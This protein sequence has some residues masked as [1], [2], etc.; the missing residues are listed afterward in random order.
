[1]RN[2]SRVAL[3]WNLANDPS[4]GPHTQGGC[5]TCKGALTIN[6]D[7]ITRNVGYYII[8][9]A[10]KFIP[11][12]STCIA[13][14][15]NSTLQNAAFITPAGTK[16]LIVENDGNDANFNIRYNHKWAT[17]SLPAGAVA[18]FTW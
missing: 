5:N 2:W 16:V 1:M 17:V 9:H 4:Y 8:A 18:T 11:A 3:E 7:A 15:L 6:G 13:S 14:N 12:G 10:S